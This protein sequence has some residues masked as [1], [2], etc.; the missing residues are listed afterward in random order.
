MVNYGL[1]AAVCV[2]IMLG[3][4]VRAEDQRAV[5]AASAGTL[6]LRGRAVGAQI[7]QCRPDASGR[8]MWMLRQPI[9][10]LISDGNTL[11]RHFAGPSWELA[12]GSLILGSVTSKADAGSPSDIPWLSIDVVQ[13]SHVG[14]LKDVRVVQRIAT[15]GGSMARACLHEGDLV[16][17]PYVADYLFSRP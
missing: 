7:Y 6:V 11:G 4:L 10:T 3:P 16:A 15:A 9:A 14:L 2:L 8:P 17:E 12:D 5:V 13:N 1:A